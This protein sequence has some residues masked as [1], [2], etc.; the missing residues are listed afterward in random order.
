LLS[1]ILPTTLPGRRRLS[2]DRHARPG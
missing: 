2:D 1:S